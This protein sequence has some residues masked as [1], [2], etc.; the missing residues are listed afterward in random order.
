MTH[1]QDSSS[2]SAAALETAALLAAATQWARHD[3]DPAT[4]ADLNRLAERAAQDPDAAAELAD[5]FDGNLQ[6]GTAG[7]RAVMGPG[8]NRMN[9][10]VVRRAAAGV[11]AH[12]LELAKGSLNAP[13]T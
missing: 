5:S 1:S 9:R 12:L 10:T 7:L 6:F 8:P 4:A 3:P 2:E 13:D 11:A